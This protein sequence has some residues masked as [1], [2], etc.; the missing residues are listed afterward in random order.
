MKKIY[1]QSILLLQ[2]AEKLAL[3]YSDKG[4]YLAFSGGKDSQCLYHIAK[5]AGVKFEAHYAHTGIDHPKLVRFIREN[6]SD[7]KID[8]PDT[9]FWRLVRKKKML[10]TKKMRYCC[11]V[12]KETK[13]AGTVTLTGVRRAEGT[14][15][16]KRN[17]FEVSN[18]LFTSDDEMEFEEWRKEQITK[19]TNQDQ[20]AEQ[21]ETEVRCVNGKDKII[22]NPILNWTDKDVW[23]FLDNVAK[24]P[25]C[26]LYD[27]GWRRLGCLFC[28]MANK[29]TL[30][31]MEREYPKYKQAYLRII[32][33]LRQDRILEGK[34][35]YWE[36]MSAE[37]VF[38]WW[39]SKQSLKE[40]KA[41]N[42]Q[43]LFF[44]FTPPPTPAT[45]P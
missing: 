17:T 22:I 15:R 33:Q 6:Y 12:L 25:H 35:D 44:N 26:K 5:L 14:K 2:K 24:V 1:E 36:E 28:P 32:E 23:Y 4:F 16:K 3:T 7:V 11:T 21:G 42:K 39:V 38:Q 20:F 34:K 40:W 31:R 8:L 41:K 19:N 29:E 13:G 45:H 27:E 10:P 30:H 18:Y 37:D 43:Q 9:T